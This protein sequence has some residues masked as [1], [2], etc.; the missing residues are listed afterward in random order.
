MARSEASLMAV[1]RAVTLGIGWRYRP[2]VAGWALRH[3]RETAKIVAWGSSLRRPPASG[4]NVMIELLEQQK[5]LTANQ[6]KLI[7]TA[8]LADLLDFFRLLSD[9]LRHRGADQAMVADLLGGRGN[10]ARLR[11]RR[12]SWRL[13]LGVARRQDRPPHGVHPVGDHHLARHRCHGFH[14]GTGRLR[15]GMALP[16]VLPLLRRRRQR[17]HF[18]DRSAAGAGVHPRLQARLGQRA[19]H[20]AAAGGQHAGRSRGL[21]AAPDRRLARPV[22]GRPGAAGPGVHDPL[23]G[24]GVAALAD[25]QGSP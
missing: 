19:H 4:R 12:G 6:W 3:P 22:P 13:L 18:H 5:K 23:V 9:R 8:N 14:A 17:R 7:C 24:A 21:A 2:L 15:P 1:P 20:D 16:D 25:A 11:S 10:P